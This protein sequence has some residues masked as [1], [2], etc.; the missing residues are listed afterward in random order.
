MAL[1]GSDAFLA[2]FETLH[3]KLIDLSLGRMQRL[4]DKM[5]NPERLLPPII[6]VAGTNGKG[7]T[8]AFMRAMLEASRAR[9]HVFTSPHLVRFHERIR[10]AGQLVAEEALIAAC[11][12]VEAINGDDPITFFEIT[13]AIAFDLFSATPA[14]YLLLEVGLGGRLDS[15]NV[16]PAPLATIITPVSMDHREFLGET[17]ALIAAE[18]AG[19]LKRGAPLILAD[20]N[21]EAAA[22]ALKAAA[23]LGIT[24]LQ[25]GQDFNAYEEQGRLIYQEEGVLLDLPLPRLAG[26]HQ[27]GNAATAIAALRCVTDGKIPVAAIEAGLLGAEWPARLQ[28]L[29]GALGKLAP[30]DAELWLDGGHNGDGARVLAEAMSAMEEKSARPLILLIGMMARKDA[31]EIITPFI[32]IAQ[33]AYAIAFANA[34]ARA[35]EDV[36]AIARGLGLPAVASG[37]VEESLRFLAARDWPVPPRI[38]ITGSL[39][40]AGVVLRANGTLP[41]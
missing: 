27:H 15:T 16:I 36:A 14:D 12:R 3:P 38:L 29:T 33:E 18:K 7:S 2:R 24:V 39:Y 28:R 9:V 1:A 30:R 4:L 13:T 19:I 20:Q 40:L 26:R 41:T 11:A 10:L 8:I 22:V 34:G 25:G 35:P 17:L 5:G 37:T 31:S 6:H 32:G 23:R 21:P